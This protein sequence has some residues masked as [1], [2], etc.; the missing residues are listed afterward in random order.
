MPAEHTPGPWEAEV[1]PDGWFEITARKP[2]VKPPV[3]IAGS[4][5]Y[6]LQVEEMRANA[7]LLAAAPDL[8]EALKRLD[9]IDRGLEGW[10]ED[11]RAEAWCKARAA[12][13]KATG[14]QA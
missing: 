14:G 1:Q 8:L 2:D 6:S 11:A 4:T 13:A 7:H 9:R 5:S 12:I 10:H 3:D